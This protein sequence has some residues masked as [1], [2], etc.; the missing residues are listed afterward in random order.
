MRVQQEG[1]TVDAYVTE[2]K[3]LAKTCNF[4]QLQDDLLRDRTVIGIEDNATRKKLLK[5]P[6]LT[7]KECIE[8]CRTHEST[9]I[10][11]KTMT[12]KEVSAVFTRPFTSKHHSA[13]KQKKSVHA[14]KGKD[15]NCTFCGKK[16]AK[17]RKQCPA[18]GKTCST[19]HK[20]NH[21]ST[22]CKSQNKQNK[23][24]SHISIVDQ[25]TSDQD[26]YVASLE[27]I[28]IFIKSNPK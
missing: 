15:I 9:S 4:G 6:K 7:L 11:I 2:L 18:W 1:D 22:V 16:H 26:D 12:Q 21:F 10:Q 14:D 27:E 3:T 25:D 28:D 5:M 19:C 17:D 23:Q 8:M 13:N 20:L 24:S